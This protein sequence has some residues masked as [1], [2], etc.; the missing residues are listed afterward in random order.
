MNEATDLA[1]SV[2]KR[3]RLLLF[4]V[5]AVVGCTLDLWSKHVVFNARGFTPDD[6]Y[7]FPPDAETYWIIDGYFALQVWVNQGALFGVG[8]GQSLLFAIVSIVAMLGIFYWLTKGTAIQSRWLVVALGLIVG[9]I[10]GNLYD[11]LGLWHSGIET[12]ENYV[13]GV[14]DFILIQAGD[15][16][17]WP[18]LNI[19][20]MLL[21]TGAIMLVIHSLFMAESKDDPET[22]SSEASED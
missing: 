11:R 2:N 20:D 9:G 8:Q 22:K 19:A 6:Y 5:L 18:N 17:R 12:H 3:S 10:I 7:F 14:R 13:N 15:D 21:V 16:L 4:L 1:G